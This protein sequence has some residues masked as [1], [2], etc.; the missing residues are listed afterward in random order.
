MPRRPAGS[1]PSGGASTPKPQTHVGT[2]GMPF[3][4]A[5]ELQRRLDATQVG[6]DRLAA[7]INALIPPGEVPTPQFPPRLRIVRGCSE[8]GDAFGVAPSSDESRCVDCCG[9]TLTA[10]PPPNSD[11]PGFEPIPF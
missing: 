7:R 5:A 8:C 1:K 3:D 11:L 10:E 4:P 6:I 9:S 2:T